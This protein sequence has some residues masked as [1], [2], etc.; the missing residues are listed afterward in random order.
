M[1]IKGPLTRLL[2]ISNRVPFNFNAIEKEGRLEL[3]ESAGGL[4]SVITAYFELL[5][6]MQ[7]DYRFG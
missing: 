3:R 2:V 1:Q 6:L 5:L 7:E 4:I